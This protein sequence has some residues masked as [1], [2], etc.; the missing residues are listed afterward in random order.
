M[1]LESCVVF[2][3]VTEDC[4]RLFETFLLARTGFSSSEES[5]RAMASIYKLKDISIVTQGSS[6]VYL[7]LF[8]QKDVW[9]SP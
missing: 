8:F 1:S 2:L 3:E 6:D 5:L 9:R 4:S 7:H